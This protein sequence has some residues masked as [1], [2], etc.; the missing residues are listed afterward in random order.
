MS[1]KMELTALGSLWSAMVPSSA[2]SGWV[3]GDAGVGKDGVARLLAD[4]VGGGHDEIARDAREDRGGD[5]AQVAGPAHPE[6]AVEDGHRIVVTP[7]LARAGRVVSP[8][9]RAD[10]L[11]QLLARRDGVAGDELGG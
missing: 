4:H 1:E 5:H 2:G 8:R 7:D 3:N 9:V 6:A 10:E 11:A